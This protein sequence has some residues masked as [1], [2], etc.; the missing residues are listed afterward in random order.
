M[1]EE[2]AKRILS[3]GPD[4]LFFILKEITRRLAEANPNRVGP[5]TPLAQI[6]SFFQSLE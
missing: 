1:T 2:E 4:T 6:F 3:L 5:A